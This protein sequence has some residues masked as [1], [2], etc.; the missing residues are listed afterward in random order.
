MARFHRYS[1]HNITLMASQKPTASYV[2]GFHAWN[3]LGRFVKKG[4][5]GILILAPIIRKKDENK[6][7]TEPDESSTA[8]GFRAAYVF[9]RLSRDLWPSLCVPNGIR[10]CH[11][12][13]PLDSS[14]HIIAQLLCWP[15]RERYR[16]FT[17]AM[18][19]S[20]LTH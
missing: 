17:P 7:D 6:G 14:K 13:S 12:E 9:D 20:G 8:V 19:F 10:E 4:V 18:S 3:K 16:L 5:K 11:L 2:A 15:G 1:W